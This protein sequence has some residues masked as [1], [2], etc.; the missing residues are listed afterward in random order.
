MLVSDQVQKVEDA[1]LL[2]IA[3]SSLM[4]S[5]HQHGNIQDLTDGLRDIRKI[6][7]A[8]EI[9]GGFETTTQML[10]EEANKLLDK[11]KELGTDRPHSPLVGRARAW[12]NSMGMGLLA[13]LGQTLWDGGKNA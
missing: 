8:L 1:P 4:W 10:T 9:V 13:K 5:C 3:Y 6:I 12:V 2:T 11:R 7:D